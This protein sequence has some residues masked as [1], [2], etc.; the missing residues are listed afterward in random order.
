LSRIHLSISLLLC[1][2]Q[3]AMG[4]QV[5]VIRYGTAE[6]LGH[7]IVYRAFQDSNNLLW[8]GTDNGL[9]RYD[10]HGFK[11]FTTKDGL[12][13]NYVF[14]IAA[15]KGQLLLA[16]FGGGLQYHNGAKPLPDSI[17]FAQV[18]YPLNIT[19][20]GNGFWVVDKN[21]RYYHIDKT[22]CRSFV[23]DDTDWRNLSKKIFW[24]EN[25]LLAITKGLLRYDTAAK[26]FARYT[27]NP[28]LDSAEIFNAISLRG[29]QMLLATAKGLLL[30]KSDHSLQLLDPEPFSLNTGNLYQLKS[31]EVLVGSRR[32]NLW[33]YDAQ[34]LRKQLLIADVAVNDILQD[35]QGA[36]WLCTYGQGLWKIPTLS[37][38]QFPLDN[39]V[40]P[41]IYIDPISRAAKVFS[42]N[43]YQY[44]F[45]KGGQ[46]L[47]K[48][49]VNMGGLQ[50]GYASFLEGNDG[51]RYYTASSTVFKERNGVKRPV[52]VASSTV[53]QLYQDSDNRYWLAQKPGL[54]TGPGFDALQPVPGLERQ[55]VRCIVEGPNKIKY[56][57]TDEGL[58]TVNAGQPLR[59]QR[60]QAAN[61][62]VSCLHYDKAQQKL[63]IGTNDGLFSLDRQGTVNPLIAD[64]RINKI[65]GDKYNNKWMAS[66]WGLLLYNQKFFQ[67]FGQEDGLQPHLAKLAYDSAAH[68]LHVLAADR[69]YAIRLQ[70]FTPADNTS[71]I[72]LLR[73]MINGKAWPIANTVQQVPEKIEQLFLEI[74]MPYYK[75][76]A[77]HT[78]Y[79]RVD[80]NRWVNANWAAELNIG[81]LYYG[82]HTVDLKVVDEINKTTVASRQLT[83]EVQTPFWQ[84]KAALA[85]LF[86]LC[87]ALGLLLLWLGW[88]YLNRRRIRRIKAAQRRIELEHKVLANMLNPH[89]MNNALNAIQAFVVKN[90]QRSTLDYLSKFARLMRINLELLEKNKI[91]LD[92]E[93]QNLSL[94]LS[95]ELLRNPSLIEYAIEVAPGIDLTRITVPPLLLQPFVENAIWHGILPKKGKGTIHIGVAQRA[96]AICITIADD[97]VGIEASQN[98]PLRHGAEKTS[99]GLQIIADRLALLNLTQPGHGFQLSPNQPNG[100]R[101]TVT[102]PL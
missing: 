1:M 28:L 31:G 20:H 8:F 96:N 42:F 44:T 18:K 47:A 64:I 71:Q 81:N 36:I 55:I 49:Q 7:P 45:D 67:V 78:L 69:Y 5:P 75:T 72:I 17:A 61:G 92:K 4:Q 2:L 38:Q 48:A 76:P 101:V 29:G 65:I 54:Y 3:A 102:L 50:V 57:G 51:Q 19:G 74:A 11:N 59:A 99:K 12:R 94:Y 97:G 84:T 56:V 79:Y 13:S 98:N 30:L 16:T 39:L 58:F 91:T 34:L 53:S 70:Q 62:F 87:L 80:G 15:H 40:S 23:Y 25:Q 14:S 73:Q 89:F 6:G 41:E 86:L 43:G 66:S 21:N 63:W 77:G 35:V 24:H 68:L 90:D 27:I 82:R 100:T 93:L 52:Y 37:V 9:T 88:R 95:F 33:L 32:G 85:T 60:L 46:R 22:G 26:E 10:G 83:Y